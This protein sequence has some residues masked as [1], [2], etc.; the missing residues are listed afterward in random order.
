MVNPLKLVTEF[1]SLLADPVVASQ[2]NITF[3]LHKGLYCVAAEGSD[4]KKESSERPQFV[5][6]RVGNVTADTV[7]L[8]EYGV[9]SD[10]KKDDSL[11]SLPFQVQVRFRR[12]SDGL[13]LIRVITET[14][15]V[16]RDREVAEK[17]VDLKVIGTHAAKQSATLAMA[18][19]Y[20]Q[21]RGYAFKAKEFLRKVKS[22]AAN[23]SDRAE[24]ESG[25]VNFK[26]NIFTME[27]SLQAAQRQEV[28]EGAC[29]SDS[30]DDDD[31]GD[32]SSS[33]LEA[34]RAKEAAKLGKK[35]AKLQSRKKKRSDS[36]ATNVYGFKHANARLLFSAKDNDTA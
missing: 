21:A 9:R 33:N 18:G 8:F 4:E 30:D 20:S 36:T 26:K 12:Q 1:A 14:K 3:I 35:K 16:T 19:E 17:S 7:E 27:E 25:Y 23:D 32:D 5:K 10:A 2:V 28:D 34:H 13:E 29:L 24:Q 11:T 6:K 31:W 15:E 22:N